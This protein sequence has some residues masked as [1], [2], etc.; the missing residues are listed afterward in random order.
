MRAKSFHRR[1]LQLPPPTLTLVIGKFVFRIFFRTGGSHVEATHQMIS[2][3]RFKMPEKESVSCSPADRSKSLIQRH[4]NHSDRKKRMEGKEESQVQRNDERHFSSERPEQWEEKKPAG[5]R[6]PASSIQKLGEFMIDDDKQHFNEKVEKS[7]PGDHSTGSVKSQAVDV[8]PFAG[9]NEL[10]CAAFA[11]ARLGYP[12]FPCQP[13]KKSPATKHGFKDATCDLVQIRKW[14]SSNPDFNIGI[15]TGAILVLDMDAGNNWLCEAPEQLAELDN[16][17]PIS[18][19]PN[20][21]KHYFFRCPDGHEW[22]S[23]AGQIATKIDTRCSS[24]YVIAAP[25]KLTDNGGDRFYRWASNC[26]L[27]VVSNELPAPPD[28]LIHCLDRIEANKRIGNQAPS[29]A[30][31]DGEPILEGKRNATL[32]SLAGSMRRKG[33]SQEAIDAALWEENKK[34]CRP[35]LDRN[36]IR[37]IS[38]SISRYPSTAKMGQRSGVMSFILPPTQEELC[39]ESVFCPTDPG[40]IPDE[41]L[42]I[43][44]FISAVKDHCI[45]TAPCPNPALAFCGALALQSFLTGRKIRNEYDIRPNIYI[46][47]LASSSAGKDHPRKLNIRIAEAVGLLP[48]LGDSFASGE[49]L[50]DAMSATPSMLFQ[51]DEI[52]SLIQ[53]ITNAKE[54]RAEPMVANL[55]KFYSCSSSVY[56]MRRKAGLEGASII[57]PHLTIFGTAIPTHY[58][59]AFSERLLTN[60][61]LPR[62]I[63]LEGGKRQVSQNAIIREIPRE[64]LKVAEKWAKFQPG[65]SNGPEPVQIKFDEE[66]NRLVRE[67]SEKCDSEYNLA[68]TRGD[69]VSM[70]IW[71]RASENAMKLSL[72]YAASQSNGELPVTISS[73][74]VAWSNAFGEYQVRKLLYLVHRHVSA[75]RFDANCKKLLEKLKSKGGE[76]TMSNLLRATSFSKSQ[77]ESLLETLLY[78][79]D[80]K[81]SQKSS[82]GG[83]PATV[84]QLT[85]LGRLRV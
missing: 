81:M 72:I 39:S 17:C 67:Y 13:G 51:T 66:A 31:Q 74:A 69:E 32:T 57:Q 68:Q 7:T 46:L 42:R 37:T 79:G 6:E 8:L 49:G 52:D 56:S 4:E 80:V 55:L 14:W 44:G 85:T 62:M 34:K 35:P 47:G 64:I 10:A 21:G 50:E 25:S 58:F 45:E 71:G 43:P 28:W 77:V 59:A 9:D 16:G 1:M 30:G 63:V 73:D 22:S 78:R 83:R 84:V 12:V 11:Y 26:D 33:L 27:T 75:G 76:L 20:N 15:A 36:E 3:R 23:S 54:G 53:S 2:K 40:E 29:H 18:I 61:F 38:T 82:G 24:G 60:G 48:H 70:A 19:T 65:D 41:L 5:G